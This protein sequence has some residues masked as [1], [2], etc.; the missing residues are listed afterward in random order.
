MKRTVSLILC[1]LLLLS[2]HTKASALN[3][4]RTV[5]GADLSPEQVAAVYQSFGIR[6]GDVTE[7]TMTNAEERRYLQGYVDESVIG[8]RSISCVYVELLPAGSGLSV[9]TNNIT[10]WTEE[11]YISALTTAGITDARIIVSAPFEVSGTSALSGVYKAYEDMTGLTLDDLAK[12]VSTE[13]LTVTG[14]L[15]QQ[16]GSLDSTSIVSELKL[17]LNETKNMS[18]E[19][20]R[21]IITEIAG[22]YNVRLTDTQINQLIS[23]CRS[24]EELNPEQLRQRVEQVQETLQKVSEAKTKVVGFAQEVKKFAESV[25]GLVDKL[26]EL[27]NRFSS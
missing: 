18:D 25:S 27:L 26:R 23:L 22:R 1:L 15:A 16:I 4:S 10:W 20:I 3:Q 21:T 11:M 19:E 8:T 13:E 17:I 9:S 6:R 12:Q 2:A 14:D 24:L 5:I 7:L